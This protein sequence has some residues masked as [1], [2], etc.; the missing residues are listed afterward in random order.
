MSLIKEEKEDIKIEKTFKVKQ[1]KLEEQ[2][3]EQFRA[4]V[5]TPFTQ[6]TIVK[7]EPADVTKPTEIRNVKIEPADVTRPTEIRNVKIEPADV[8]RPTG[9][10]NAEIYIIGDSCVRYGEKR[11]RETVGVN[12]G[13]N[14]RVQWFG[15]D[16]LV[17]KNL[18][19]C[20]RQC[21][22]TRA[23]PDVLL[24]HC[25]GNDLG[26]FKSVKLCAAITQDLRELHRSFP[27]M[28]MVFSTITQRHKWGSL[29]P[30]K[31]DR[32]RRFINS[33]MAKSVSSVGGSIV[34]HPQINYR[35][36]DLFHCDGINFSNRGNDIF[37]KNITRCL[38]FH[39]N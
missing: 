11:A 39:M 35:D 9:I 24:I 6:I 37:L 13:L 12:L 1:E 20:F 17:W 10:R 4:R 25:G 29:H 27:Q 8:T 2:T 21:L 14:A 22:R 34:Q 3:D 18:L 16:G 30:K 19:P 23:V 36:P 32:A 26:I 31:I 5:K 28:K 7:I 38:K 33:M 15:F